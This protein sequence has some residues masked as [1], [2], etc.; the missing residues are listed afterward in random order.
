MNTLTYFNF[1]ENK[2]IEIPV[3]GLPDVLVNPN[4]GVAYRLS[5]GNV[6]NI[7]NWVNHN[8][9]PIHV[10]RSGWIMENTHA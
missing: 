1:T 6:Y 2:V 4:T 7:G 10:G 9:S 3:N 5:R 8:K